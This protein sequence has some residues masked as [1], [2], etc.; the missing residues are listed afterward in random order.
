MEQNADKECVCVISDRGDGALPSRLGRLS[1]GM[2]DET[3]SP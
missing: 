1:T 3:I 2:T